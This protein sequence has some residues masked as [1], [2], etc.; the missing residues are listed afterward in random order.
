MALVS[1]VLP[2]YNR[3]ATIRAAVDSVLAQT[4]A[5]IE[6]IV[7]DDASTDGTRATLERIDDPRLRVLGHR[8]NLGASA[9]RN[10]G[11]RASTGSLI[12]FHD[13][14]DVWHPRKL[15]F[16]VPALLDERADLGFVYCRMRVHGPD[17][18]LTLVPRDAKLTALERDLPAELIHHNYVGTPSLVVRRSVVDAVG[19][20]DPQMRGLEDWDF[21]IRIANRTSGRLIDE[22]LVDV[23][24]SH[25]SL[26][27]NAR[28]LARARYHLLD[29]HAS[30]FERAGRAVHAYET[31]RIAIDNLLAGETATGRRLLLRSLR[32]RPAALGVGALVA[33]ALS[34]VA[35]RA[36]HRAYGRHRGGSAAPFEAP[37]H[38][39]GR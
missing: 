30:L 13:S 14:D 18:S 34:P 24:P 35:F 26:T 9:A 29:K 3:N 4:Y 12:A 15:E 1:V 11:I 19:Y 20:F 36:I 32:I 28:D 21:V 7:V 5:D 25:D 8:H 10:S 22:P 6:V 33:A 38:R 23:H 39:G 37:A 17:G 16:Q 31:R 2:T 27:R